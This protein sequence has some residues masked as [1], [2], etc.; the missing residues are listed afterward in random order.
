MPQY[1]I[2]DK[3][4]SGG[5]GEVYRC[6]RTDDS[7]VFAI[8]RLSRPTEGDL[9]RFRREVR[10]QATLKHKHIV[11]ILGFNLNDATPWFVMPLALCSVREHL[12]RKRGESEVWIVEQAARG[13][14][15]AHS[16]GIIHRDLKPENLLILEDA[17]KR[18]YVAIS[19]FGLGRFAD[20][21]TATLTVSNAPLGTMVYMAPEQFSNAKEVDQRADI[22]S[23]GKCLYEILVGELPYPHV[24]LNK[25]PSRFRFLVHKACESS[26]EKRY[27]TAEEFLNDLLT[28]TA[29]EAH[30]TNPADAVQA[31][32][33]RLLEAGQFGGN[34]LEPLA[35]LLLANTDDNVILTSLLPNLPAVVLK[36]LLDHHLEGMRTVLLA[37]D[38]AISGSISFSFCDKVADFYAQVFAATNDHRI[39][40]MILV[41]LADLGASH[42]RWHVGGVLK[43]LVNGLTDQSLLLPLKDA[44]VGSPLSLRFNASYL[45]ELSLPKILRDI[46]P[47]DAD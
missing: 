44:L 11:P 10:M 32:L 47:K 13:L 17:N 34:A 30:L 9:A 29:S 39:R 41:R 31:E 22:Y 24:D 6:T 38:D 18:L 21:D 1:Q 16:N 19:D 4:G 26:A 8:K 43:A 37:F 2:G 36:G 35:K 14:I 12:N 23:L 28:V 40:V 20:R 42:N 7:N 25:V 15:Q 5:F 45:R 46:L 3:L 33:K 27:Q